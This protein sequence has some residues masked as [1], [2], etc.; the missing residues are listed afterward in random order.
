MAYNSK[1]TNVYNPKKTIINLTVTIES[2]VFDIF[3]YEFDTLCVDS[4][5]PYCSLWEKL[6]P[7]DSLLA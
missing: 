1:K 6:Y 2:D 3:S 5:S 7:D 4:T